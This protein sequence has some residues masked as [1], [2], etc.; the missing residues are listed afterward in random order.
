[1]ECVIEWNDGQ[2]FVHLKVHHWGADTQCRLLQHFAE[3]KADLKKRG[4]AH[5][6]TY[7]RAENALWTKFVR[8][9][10]FTYL[11]TFQQLFRVYFT[12]T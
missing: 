10:G 3:L 5:V 9:L 7:T 11:F 2:P 1:M 4:F 6:F 8:S 12:E